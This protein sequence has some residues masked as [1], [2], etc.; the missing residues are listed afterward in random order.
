MPLTNLIDE[1]KSLAE[2]CAKIDYSDK[3]SIRNNNKAVGRMYKIVEKIR[4]DFG[5]EGLS[6]FQELLDVPTYKTNLWVAIQMLEKTTV[7]REV[8]NKALK[9]IEEEA[10][11]ETTNAL[12]TS[13][14]L[15]DYKKKEK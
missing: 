6:Q 11:G 8:E 7:S 9:I 1:Y 15:K 4:D 5:V 12:G 3:K 14:W 10:K 13:I 2:V